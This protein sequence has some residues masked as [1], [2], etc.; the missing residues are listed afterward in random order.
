M[1]AL[2]LKWKQIEKIIGVC[3][4]TAFMGQLYLNPFSTG[5]R[6]SFSVVILSLLLI[7]FKDISIIATTNAVGITIAM[8][9]AFVQSTGHPNLG[10]TQLLYDYYPVAFFYII[11]GILYKGLGVRDKIELP[12][13]FL[14]VL[15]LCDSISNILE[16]V[17]RREWTGYSFEKMVLVIIFMGLLRSLVTI[18]IY[19][20]SAYYMGRYEREQRESKY[21]K[22]VMF[23]ASLKAEIFFLRKSMIDIE[24]AMKESYALYENIKDP[25]LKD[26]ALSVAK[27]I[28]EIKKDYMRVTTGIEK[29]ISEENNNYQ[30][31]LKEIFSIIKD[32]TE[33]I[34]AVKNKHITLH[35]R[36][37]H[38]FITVEFYQLISV[39]NNLIINSID[40]IEDMGSIRIVQEIR[41]GFCIFE[42]IDDGCGIET[43]EIDLVFEPGFSTKFNRV[44]GEL[45][46]GI[47]LTHV[48]HIV[49]RYFKGSIGVNSD[50]NMKTVFEIVI[51]INNIIHGKW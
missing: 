30:M 27:D 39:L 19:Y 34:I 25:Y 6:L 10:W 41:G 20:M 7:Y 42:I 47:G 22:M 3:I 4:I 44:T 43:E 29:T 45:S 12:G 8:F 18:C 38:N 37:S 2:T 16:V 49:E 46:T 11:F 9:R 23:M 50:N 48:K 14:M 40:A 13:Q 51:P 32:N 36:Y 5:F 31:S 26:H 24:K 21:R 35:F 28:H 17:L 33:K 15:W 1:L